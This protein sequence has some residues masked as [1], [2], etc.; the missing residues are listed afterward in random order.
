MKDGIV[1]RGVAPEKVSVIQNS[2]DLDLFDVP[3]SEGKVFR[4]QHAWLGERPLVVYCGALGLINGVDYLVRLASEVERINPEVRFLVVGTGMQE[5]TIRQQAETLGVLNRNFFM[6]DCAPKREMPRILSAADVSTSLFIDLPAMRANSANK[7]FDAL[8]AG[9]PIAVNHDGWLADL[10]RERGLGL[11]LDPS[12]FAESAR[13]LVGFLK[14]PTEIQS[15][16]LAA[17][18]ASRELFDRDVLAAQLEDVLLKAADRGRAF[19][20]AKKRHAHAA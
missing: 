20:P 1:S 16:R 5:G 6:Q 19:V 13:A 7:F 12:D 8:A 11:V 17:R 2:C 3:A 4:Q 15:A 14:N 9:R 18:R 10:V